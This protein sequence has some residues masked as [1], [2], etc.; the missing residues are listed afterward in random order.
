MTLKNWKEALKREP[1]NYLYY[2]SYNALRSP[3]EYYKD[4]EG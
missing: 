4:E 2:R 1:G 3:K